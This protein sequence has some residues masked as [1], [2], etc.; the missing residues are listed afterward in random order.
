M[1]PSRAFAMLRFFP[2]LSVR[3]W[4]V[5]FFRGFERLTWTSIHKRLKCFQWRWW[6]D[7]K[8][9]CNLY[10]FPRWFDCCKGNGHRVL[11]ALLRCKRNIQYIRNAETSTTHHHKEPKFNQCWFG[12]WNQKHHKVVRPKDDRE[13]L[14]KCGMISSRMC[15]LPFC[16]QVPRRE[17]HEIRTL[18][19]N[20]LYQQFLAVTRTESWSRQSFRSKSGSQKISLM[21]IR[22][23]HSRNIQEYLEVFHSFDLPIGSSLE[24]RE[25][26]VSSLLASTIDS[27]GPLQ[28]L[29]SHRCHDCHESP[30]FLRIWNRFGTETMLIWQLSRLPVLAGPSVPPFKLWTQI[31]GTSHTACSQEIVGTL[32]QSE[33]KKQIWRL[34]WM[35]NG[36]INHTNA[37]T[38][39]T[40]LYYILVISQN[41]P[42]LATVGK[43]KLEN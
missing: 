6:K 8:N 34:Q 4:T 20:C 21:S 24:T 26:S 33:E 10:S 36:I 30:T 15:E 2:Q 27:T 14:W 42:G 11:N 43:T 29:H 9:W 32:E 22:A 28:Q 37:F 39:F 1:L 31:H 5:F 18:S 3:D 41:T 17:G 40:H 16:C 23:Y 35:E 19:P 12:R 7:M 38:A 25:R 13:D